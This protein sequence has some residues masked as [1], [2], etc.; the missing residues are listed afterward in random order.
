MP[1]LRN[2]DKSKISK[3]KNAVS[4]KH[5]HDK[6]YLKEALLNFLAL[7]GWHPKSDEEIFSISEL[8]FQVK[9]CLKNL[10]LLFFFIFFLSHSLAIRS[11]CPTL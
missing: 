5:Y 6:G 1:I 8:G 11:C 9:R 7:M 10:T 3:R 4:L 2:A